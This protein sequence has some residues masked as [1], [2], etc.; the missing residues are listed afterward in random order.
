MGEGPGAVQG[1]MVGEMA[2]NSPVKIVP[3]FSSEQIAAGVQRVAGEV[4]AH[5]GVTEPVLAL[6]LLGGNC[7]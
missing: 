1:D 6:C 4:Q 2:Y 5:F 3:L 7:F